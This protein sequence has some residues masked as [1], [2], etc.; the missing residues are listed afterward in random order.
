MTSSDVAAGLSGGSSTDRLV[1]IG[2][3]WLAACVEVH[4][5]PG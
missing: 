2:R 3:S 5:F 4:S 1:V